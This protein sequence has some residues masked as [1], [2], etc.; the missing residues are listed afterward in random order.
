MHLLRHI[1]G[2]VF[3]GIQFGQDHSDLVLGTHLCIFCPRIHDPGHLFAQV[4]PVHVNP[5]EAEFGS[6]CPGGTGSYS[7]AI[8]SVSPD[9]I[10]EFQESIFRTKRS[11]DKAGNPLMC[12]AGCSGYFPGIHA[13]TDATTGTDRQGHM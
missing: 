6:L 3:D 9:K 1:R 5:F 12:V 11:M 7:Q 13:S 4:D 8:H 10:L 2:V